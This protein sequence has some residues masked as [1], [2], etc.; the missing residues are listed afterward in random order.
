VEELREWIRA[1]EAAKVTC[2]N[3]PEFDF[4]MRYQKQ[5]LEELNQ[6]KMSQIKLSPQI[7]KAVE[8]FHDASMK[9]IAQANAADEPKEPLFHYTSEKALFSIIGS[10]KFWFT[11]IYHMDD[12][13]EL[14]FGFNV[15][16]SLLQIAVATGD[17]LTRMFCE[18]LVD[19]EDLK[20][21]RTLFEFYSISFGLKDDP[22]Q[23]ASYGDSGRGVA[24]GLAPA[25]F[26][27][28]P[29]ADPKN[30]KPEEHIYFGRVLYGDR[31][32]RTCHSI[33]IDA[34]IEAIKQAHAA[35]SIRNGQDAMM[36]FRHIAA[37]MTIEI[38][39]NC[40]T[41]KD[42]SWS[43]QN[44]T[45]LLALNNLKSPHLPIYNA[46]KRPRLEIPQPLLKKNVVEVMVGPN[47]DGGAKERVRQFLTRH[48]LPHIP[49]TRA[50][51]ACPRKLLP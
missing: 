1:A 37:E 46:D 16:R 30:P 19:E 8:A 35:G 4:L 28:A 50:G 36:F 39:W 27:P 13:E 14:T 23:W 6:P 17:Q 32:A 33:V 41:T 51:T 25:F 47:V 22:Q 31:A 24:L 15:S 40:V 12:K 2:L 38:L 26:H 7:E 29:F 48:G 49:V 3:G 5:R 18:E 20:K 45:R 9:R 11:S 42:S 21:I 44:E 43:H 10:E 34:A